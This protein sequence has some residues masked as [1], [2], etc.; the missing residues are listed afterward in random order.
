MYSYNIPELVN[1][2][3]ELTPREVSKWIEN[4]ESKVNYRKS[5]LSKPG[6]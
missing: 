3:I 2:P 4:P 5:D 6:M 1:A